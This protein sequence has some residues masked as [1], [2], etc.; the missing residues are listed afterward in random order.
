MKKIILKDNKVFEEMTQITEKEIST[1]EIKEQID[2]IEAAI[3]SLTQ[4]KLELEKEFAEVEESE[5][6]I[7]IE[8]VVEK[9]K[10]PKK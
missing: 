6:T 5:K 4:R 2:Q 3:K 10:K 1:N 7:P 9:P 8:K